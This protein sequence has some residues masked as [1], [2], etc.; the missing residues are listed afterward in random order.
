LSFTQADFSD[1]G[2]D[3]IAADYSDTSQVCVSGDCKLGD[4]DGNGRVQMDDASLVL[5][6]SVKKATP[7]GC[8]FASADLN[9]DWSIDC[10]DAVMI[11]RIA[12]DRP[13]NPG[14]GDSTARGRTI[15]VYIPDNLTTTAG[16]TLDVPVMIDD[17]MGVSGCDLLLAFPP[18]TTSLALLSVVPGTATEDFAMAYEAGNGY[19]YVS[20]SRD[21]ALDGRKTPQSLA[22]LQFEIPA[23]APQNAHLSVA[24]NAAKLSGQFGD[25][26]AWYNDVE[27]SGNKITVSSLVCGAAAILTVDEETSRPILDA[28]VQLKPGPPFPLTENSE[29]IYI[30]NCINPGSCHVTVAAPDYS[31]SEGDIFIESGDVSALTIRMRKAD[32]KHGCVGGTLASTPTP[33][34]GLFGDPLEWILIAGMLALLVYV[35]GLAARREGKSGYD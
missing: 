1:V 9:G 8:Q 30:F 7:Q 33:R 20:M 2:L 4:V 17:I 6:I 5:K 3:A 29:G 24:L 12:C 28:L 16:T 13:V 15:K 26:F 11:Q 34:D 18:Q 25:D 23:T 14:I 32:D 22:V 27:V 31:Q 10:A 19:V 35:R 21:R